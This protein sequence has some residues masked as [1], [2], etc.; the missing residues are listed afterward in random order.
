MRTQS[1]QA[2]LTQSAGTRQESWVLP[3]VRPHLWM[4]L[5]KA[6]NQHISL[7]TTK[8]PVQPPL[9]SS[10]AQRSQ[11]PRDQGREGSGF[12]MS[13][14]TSISAWAVLY[15]SKQRPPCCPSPTSLT[16]LWQNQSFLPLVTCSMLSRIPL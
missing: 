9:G 1:L 5:S 3:S 4:I 8:I 6:F 16:S 7:P 13:H 10:E 12:K 15:A 14:L 11:H 2:G